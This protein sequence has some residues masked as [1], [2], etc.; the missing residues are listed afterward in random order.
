MTVHEAY[1]AVVDFVKRVVGR[2]GN[3]VRK[4]FHPQQYDGDDSL[5]GKFRRGNGRD[6]SGKGQLASSRYANGRVGHPTN[7]WPNVNISFNPFD[8]EVG[9]YTSHYNDG[10]TQVRNRYGSSM[11]PELP[12]SHPP[13]PW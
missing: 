7:S 4:C 10:Q 9:T 13:P 6:K 11:Q 1:D 3:G 2:A 8:D 5:L 12:V